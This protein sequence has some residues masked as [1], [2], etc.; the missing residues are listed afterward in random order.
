MVVVRVDSRINAKHKPS[1]DSVS[2][3]HVGVCVY[4]NVNVCACA[5]VCVCVCVWMGWWVDGWVDLYHPSVCV[6]VLFEGV[7]LFRSE[8]HSLHACVSVCARA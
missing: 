3:A 4:A 2:V 7:H 1:G 6:C 5:C 8:V